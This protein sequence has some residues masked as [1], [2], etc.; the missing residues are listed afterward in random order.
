MWVVLT[1]N[2]FY[3]KAVVEFRLEPSLI[4]LDEFEVGEV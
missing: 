2:G 4:G 1:I 3:V